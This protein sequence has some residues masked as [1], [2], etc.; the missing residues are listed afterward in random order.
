M[1]KSCVSNNG[2][3]SDFFPISRGVR[4]GCPLSPYLFIIAIEIL[5][6]SIKNENEIKGVQM[7]N[8]EL[9]NTMFADDATFMTDGSKSSFEN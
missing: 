2:Y 6:Q 7:Y 9:K 5:S 1:Q 4:Q 3:L 8:I